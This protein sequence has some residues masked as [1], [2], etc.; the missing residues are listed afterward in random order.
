MKVSILFSS[1]RDPNGPGW[2]V[3]ESIQGETG[4]T[5][6]GPMPGE[7]VESFIR[8]RRI[9]FDREFRKRGATK[10]IEAQPQTEETE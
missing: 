6:H 5:E 1:R 2:F 9:F 10:I 7:V 3:L 8:A 4:G